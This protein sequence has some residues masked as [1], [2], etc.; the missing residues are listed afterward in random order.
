M[1]GEARAATPARAH[2]GIHTGDTK[3]GVGGFVRVQYIRLHVIQR[4]GEYQVEQCHHHNCTGPQT[5]R[6]IPVLTLVLPV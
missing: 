4:G 1:L 2:T 3:L 6:R 5:R